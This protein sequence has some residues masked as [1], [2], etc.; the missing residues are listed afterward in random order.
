MKKKMKKKMKNPITKNKKQNKMSIFQLRQFSIFFFKNFMVLGLV[1]L[2]EVAPG[3]LVIQIQIQAVCFGIV[4]RRSFFSIRILLTF[5]KLN[6]ELIS[7]IFGKQ[8]H[9]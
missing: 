7:L 9:G 6:F 5:S 8:S 2:S 3:L 4:D 1:G